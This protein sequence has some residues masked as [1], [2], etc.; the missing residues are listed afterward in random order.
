[1]YPIRRQIVEALRCRKLPRLAP[2]ETH[3]NHMRAWP[4]DIDPFGDLNNGR[5]IT[6]M[7]VGRIG[8]AQR[9]GLIKA[10]RANRW[11][12][13]MAGSTPQYRRRVTMWERLEF[14][15]RLVAR[16][17]RFFFIEQTLY[18]QDGE[19]GAAP[20]CNMMCR[21]VITSRGGIVPTDDV[22]AAIGRPDWNAEAPQWALDWAAADVARPW[23]PDPM[24][25]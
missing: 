20:A 22:A 15:S 4:W 14:R 7:D 17:A 9:T 12:L 25:D 8:L 3:V 21:T 16:D 6:L 1:M 10:M 5:I 13:A 19:S 23:P 2:G 18:V 24:I 11:G